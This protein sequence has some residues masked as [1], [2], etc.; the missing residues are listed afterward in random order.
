MTQSANPPG[1]AASTTGSSLK[2]PPHI[3]NIK[4][5][6]G[7]TAPPLEP[8]GY[9]ESTRLGADKTA[10][11]IDN[12]EGILRTQR[13]IILSL[14][15]D[16]HAASSMVEKLTELAVQVVPQQGPAGPLTRSHA[17]RSPR[18]CRGTETGNCQRRTRWLDKMPM[19]TLRR[20]GKSARPS[21]PAVV[22]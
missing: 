19:L 1:A 21:R 15:D 11:V 6:T 9:E 5:F 3:W 4:E 10:I 18:M 22:S 2:P 20:E 7:S 14:P 16:G 12:G 17:L 13:S 8:G